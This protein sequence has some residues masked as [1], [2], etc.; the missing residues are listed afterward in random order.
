MG[1][2][3]LSEDNL[4][5]R[6]LFLLKVDPCWL[7]RWTLHSTQTLTPQTEHERRTARTT[8]CSTPGLIARLQANC[9]KR[10]GDALNKCFVT[11]IAE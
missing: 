1:P 8:F 5:A 9:F 6:E 10:A 11:G 2:R 4:Q 3:L 7:L